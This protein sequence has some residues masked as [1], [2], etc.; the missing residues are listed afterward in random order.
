MGERTAGRRRDWCMVA[1]GVHS[2]VCCCTVWNI[3]YLIS[4]Y[5][6]LRRPIE[7]LT[8]LYQPL[9]V[10]GHEGLQPH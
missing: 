7:S 5:I 3:E 10:Q 6:L 4:P 9:S 1:L 2:V 8:F